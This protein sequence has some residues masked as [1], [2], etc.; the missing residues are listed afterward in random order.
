[1]DRLTKF[2]RPLACMGVIGIAVAAGGC[3]AL[4]KE[5]IVAEPKEVR[6]GVPQK[7]IDSKDV[8]PIPTFPL[9][10]VDLT[11]SNTELVRLVNAATLERKIRTEYVGKVQEVIAKCTQ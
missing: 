9:D 6:I 8:P 5:T 7:C 10:A 2:V 11:D 3:A 1:M 4:T